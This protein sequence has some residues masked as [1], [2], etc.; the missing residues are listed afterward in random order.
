MCTYQ[1]VLEFI[2]QEVKLMANSQE[3]Q[4][5]VVTNECTAHTIVFEFN[6]GRFDSIL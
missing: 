5:S 2:I 1:A 6:T 3:Q 4:S